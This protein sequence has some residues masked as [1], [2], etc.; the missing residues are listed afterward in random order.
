MTNQ[1]MNSVPIRGARKVSEAMRLRSAR[2]IVGRR[3]KCAALAQ[4]VP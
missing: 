2:R 4:D 3:E 1:V